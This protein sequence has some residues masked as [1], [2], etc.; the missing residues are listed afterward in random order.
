MKNI[1]ALAVLALISIVGLVGCGEDTGWT[2]VT[3]D[4]PRLEAAREQARETYPDFLKA[5]KK[6]GP[7]DIATVEVLYEGTE[8]ITVTV[9]K[10]DENEIVG[11][12]DSYPQEV[13]IQ[14]GAEVTVSVSDLSDWMI[15]KDD[16]ETLGGYVQ[17]ER[18]R[19][20]QPGN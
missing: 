17:A 19:L 2:K 5:L 15:D 11:I 10:A 4:D 7:Y 14:K 13:S 1:L 6:R 3:D 9:L 20:S 18:I 8:Y 16:G 12:V